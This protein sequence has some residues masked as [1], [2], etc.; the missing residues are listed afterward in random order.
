MTKE[1][2]KE[3][4]FE[5]FIRARNDRGDW[6]DFMSLD[7]TALVRQCILDQCGFPRSTLYQNPKIKARLA[8]VE[9]QLRAA[10]TLKSETV[11]E[12]NELMKEPAI[13]GAAA[14]LESRL[15]SLQQRITTLSSLID[16]ARFRAKIDFGG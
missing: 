5:A 4:L 14:E 3:D 10:G 2:T 1:M 7:R 11:S 15:S 13:L 8:E 12:A 16:E 6:T 9:A